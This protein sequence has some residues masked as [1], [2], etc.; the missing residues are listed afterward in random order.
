[1]RLYHIKIKLHHAPPK[2]PKCPKTPIAFRAKTDL[3]RPE[4]V[5]NGPFAWFHQA[6]ISSWAPSSRQRC[7]RP[8]GVPNP[9]IIAIRNGKKKMLEPFKTSC[10][11]VLQLLKDWCLNLGG[12]IGWG[13]WCVSLYFYRS[14]Q[15]IVWRK[16]LAASESMWD[17]KVRLIQ[18][19]IS[20]I[21]CCWCLRFCVHMQKTC[22]A[23]SELAMVSELDPGIVDLEVK[24]LTHLGCGTHLFNRVHLWWFSHPQKTSSFASELF[25]SVWSNG[26]TSSKYPI[27]RNPVPSHP[28]WCPWTRPTVTRPIA[29]G[30]W[31]R[32]LGPNP[33]SSP[34][35]H[36][37]L[38]PR[39][40]RWDPADAMPPISDRSWMSWFRRNLG[41]FKQHHLGFTHEFDTLTIKLRFGP[42][43]NCWIWEVERKTR[44]PTNPKTARYV[45]VFPI[46]RE[47]LNCWQKKSP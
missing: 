23:K 11:S 38:P 37:D 6:G 12:R 5:K 2:C 1:M 46:F 9:P 33:R 28:R 29:S 26:Q 8:S 17:T 32:P 30:I 34:A 15:A 3:D 45:E 21:L 47:T 7:C 41:R 27:I 10:F 16:D 31:A 18:V 20:S 4:W 35:V 24:F 39:P 42:R 43:K 44:Q 14:R 25:F 36:R 19:S 13:N 40:F 22:T